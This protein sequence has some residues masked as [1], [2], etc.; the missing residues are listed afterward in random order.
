M[1]I[2]PSSPPAASSNKTNFSDKDAILAT[3]T[4]TSFRWNL[5]NHVMKIPVSISATFLIV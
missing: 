3:L 5:S 2:V 1:D 4:E